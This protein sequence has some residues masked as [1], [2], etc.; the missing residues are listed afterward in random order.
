MGEEEI[1]SA[2][3]VR[4]VTTTPNCSVWVCEVLYRTGGKAT[5]AAVPRNLE[6]QASRHTNTLRSGVVHF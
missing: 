3:T 2:N 5:G 4:S 6:P 1:R